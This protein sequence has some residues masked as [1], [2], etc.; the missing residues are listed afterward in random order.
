[1]RFPKLRPLPQHRE[2]ITRF[3][4][5]NRSPMAAEQ[6]FSHMENL[7]C[8]GFPLLSTRG[9]RGV[10]AAPASP[11]GLIAKESLCYVDGGDFVIGQERIPMNL[12]V[13]PGDCPKQ[14]ISMGAYV[15]ILPDKQ[16][17]NTADPRDFGPMEAETSVTGATV[18]LCRSDGRDYG[19]YH[20]G[21]NPPE[22]PK[23]GD[24]WLDTSVSPNRLKQYAADTSQWVQVLT[25]CLRIA[26]TG[27]GR[28]FGKLDGVTL[29][30]P[31]GVLPEL[32]G[33]NILQDCGE[34]YI[35]ITGILPETVTVEGTLTVSRKMP[36]MD[37]VVESGN[38]LWGCRYGMD[39]QGEF[40]N[41][42]YASALGDFRN[43]NRFLGV[44]TDSYYANVG[45]D[46]P[47]TGAASYLGEVWFFKETVIH[48]VWGSYPS[49]FR[50]LSTPGMG[51]E[52]GS[53]RSLITLGDALYYKSR[54]GVCAFDGSQ[55][56]V[57]SRELGDRGYSQAVSGA[58]G[59]K[60][61]I[62]M[63]S[64]EGRELLVYDTVRNLW[65]R[66]DDFSP[67]CFSAHRGSLYAI[68]EKT[69]NILRL[70]GPGPVTEGQ[71]AWQA[72]TAPL[73]LSDPDQKYLSRVTA[74]LALEPE[75]E[76]I[77]EARYDASS[78]WEELAVIH[79]SDFRS[80]TIPVLPRR[81]D[82]LQ[83]RLRGRGAMKLYSLTKTMEGGSDIQW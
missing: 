23:G 71:V 72:V 41:R 78:F 28:P 55:S 53:H 22:S 34:D 30:F 38:R 19:T 67:Q 75:G 33:A 58:L 54:S 65:H 51:V 52:P 12:S 46:G 18:S 69:R 13:D 6:E 15:I 26:A 74:R 49:E 16:Y 59:S 29:S 4:G 35:V 10:Y 2:V 60:L 20:L 25:T 39:E 56:R 40:V 8:D 57:I 77:L 32:N 79:S 61:Y 44:S 21:Q 47:F 9:G 14:L 5:L 7:S 73:G 48:R 42:I 37:F 45:S 76:L 36:L 68:D 63:A 17:I 70:A 24:L 31:Q 64:R 43:W 81:C 83:L 27:I 82:F 1:M 66:E 50:V 62:S 3:G 11:Q 80:F